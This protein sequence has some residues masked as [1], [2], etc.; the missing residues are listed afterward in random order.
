M[1]FYVRYFANVIETC[2]IGI[3][4][5]GTFVNVEDE[6][7]NVRSFYENFTVLYH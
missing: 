7:T 6:S 1:I 3:G 5:N 4:N 2:S